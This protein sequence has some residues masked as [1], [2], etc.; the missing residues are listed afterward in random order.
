MLVSSDACGISPSKKS[1]P[2]P[3]PVSLRS[4]K[5]ETTAAVEYPRSRSI[6]GSIR[7]PGLTVKPMLSR[8]PVSNGRR[9]ESSE[10][11]AGSV[12]GACE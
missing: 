6:C 2:W 3:I 1:N 4:T 5:A 10:A 11:W 8:T 9:P 12:C 7:S